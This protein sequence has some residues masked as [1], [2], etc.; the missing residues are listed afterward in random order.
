M[1]DWSQNNL[2]CKNTWITLRVLEQSK[3]AFDDSG[4]VRMDELEYWNPADS[5]AMR[6][7]KARSLA[8]QVDNIFRDLS[9]A[10]YEKDVTRAKAVR[11]MVDALADKDRTMSDLASV[12]DSNYAFYGEKK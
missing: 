6:A 12:N 9:G 4:G 7:A 5:P 3:K 10:E 2:A 11:D 8:I 1:A